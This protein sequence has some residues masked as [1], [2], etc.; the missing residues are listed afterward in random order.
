MIQLLFMINILA[1]NEISAENISKFRKYLKDESWDNIDYSGTHKAFTDFQG[2]INSY[3]DKC[4]QKQT[5]TITYKNRYP[6]MTN[7]LRN[8]V[9]PYIYIYIYI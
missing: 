1:L 9:V 2:L 6:W 5:F 8:K 4:F 7:S 3:F